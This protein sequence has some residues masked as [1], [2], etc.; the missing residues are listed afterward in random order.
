MSA[1]KNMSID[2]IVGSETYEISFLEKYGDG[3]KRVVIPAN[4]YYANTFMSNLS[5]MS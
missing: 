2:T 4:T 5:I 1:K 3:I